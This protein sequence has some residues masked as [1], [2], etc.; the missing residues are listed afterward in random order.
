[1]DNDPIVAPTNLLRAAPA[2]GRLG[3]LTKDLLRLV[4]ERRIRYVMV[5]GI[6]HFGADE[7]DAYS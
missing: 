1:V 2:A 3:L 7:L 6:A 4:H 5:E